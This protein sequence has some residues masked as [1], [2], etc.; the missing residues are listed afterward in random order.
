MLTQAEFITNT[1]TL[2]ETCPIHGVPLMQLDRVVK[3]AGEDK[4]RKPSPFCPKCA[5]E[6]I[7]KQEQEEIEKHLNARSIRKPITCLCVTV[8]SQK[9]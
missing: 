5:K 4:P 6:Q 1:K 9:T 3:I 8:P 2:A 7:D